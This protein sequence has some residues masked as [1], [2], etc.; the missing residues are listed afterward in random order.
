[1]KVRRK[2]RTGWTSC[3]G[4]CCIIYM[5]EGVK[6]QLGAIT[7]GLTDHLLCEIHQ[8]LLPRSPETKSRD[9]ELNWP[10]DG[11]V[12]SVCALTDGSVRQGPPHRE[13][14]WREV[15]KA[16]AGPRLGES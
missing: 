3:K 1:M 11:H 7:R 2:K 16:L 5:S 9:Q 4:S 15:L 14:R 8:C 10:Q 12:H 6:T 13:S